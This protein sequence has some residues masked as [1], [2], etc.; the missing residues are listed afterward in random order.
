MR[1]GQAPASLARV[2]GTESYYFI[3]MSPWGGGGDALVPR[4]LS[5]GAPLPFSAMGIRGCRK[6]QADVTCQVPQPT[7]HCLQSLPTSGS[8]FKFCLILEWFLFGSESVLPEPSPSLVVSDS[9]EP[10][11]SHRERGGEYP[12][13]LPIQKW[14]LLMQPAPKC[15]WERTLTARMGQGSCELEPWG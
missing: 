7:P 1:S 15:T 12:P 13:L 8:T 14:L 5:L 2:Q 3:T 11:H 6:H 10:T 9:T 4:L